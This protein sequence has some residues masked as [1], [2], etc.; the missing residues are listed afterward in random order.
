MSVSSVKGCVSVGQEG[1]SYSQNAELRWENKSVKQGMK[2]QVLCSQLI[3]KTFMAHIVADNCSLEVTK[4]LTF[5]LCVVSSEVHRE[6]IASKLLLAW[7]ECLLHPVPRTHSWLRFRPTS[8][9]VWSTRCS[10]GFAPQSLWV[11]TFGFLRHSGTT[12]FSSHIW[13]NPAEPQT[14]TPQQSGISI[15]KSATWLQDLQLTWWIL[16]S[17]L[18]FVFFFLW[19]HMHSTF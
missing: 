1:S 13:K 17:S 6:C 4:A 14:T 10:W 5:L 2:Y 8:E 3:E 7:K 19:H 12:L 15:F 18:V 11:C 9:T 16:Y